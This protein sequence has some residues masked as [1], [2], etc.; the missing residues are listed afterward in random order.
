MNVWPLELE[1]DLV[2]GALVEAGVVKEDSWLKFR[3]RAATRLGRA[4]IAAQLRSVVRQSL[5]A[6][7]RCR[8]VLRI[9]LEELQFES[10]IPAA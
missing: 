1:V 4:E 9:P 6:Q 3:D 8:K 10:G 2:F 7:V 5:V